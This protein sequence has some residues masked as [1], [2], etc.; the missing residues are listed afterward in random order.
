MPAEVIKNWFR[1]SKYA[2]M[3]G[4]RL[5]PI[6]HPMMK[7][8]PLSVAKGQAEA[9]CMAS[10]NNQR[11]ILKKFHEGKSLDRRYLS[12]VNSVL[13]KNEA[14]IV[15]SSRK[16]LSFMDLRKSAGC[17]YA[18]DLADWLNATILMPAAAGG[19]WA[20][21]ADDIR[22][23]EVQLKRAQRI[24]LARNL[25]GVVSAL[26]AHGCSHRDL[27]SGNVF[28]V[29]TTRQIYLI[30]FDSLYHPSLSMPGATTCGTDGYAA[31][32]AWDGDKLIPGRTW[33]RCADRYALAIL[34]VEFLMLA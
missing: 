4:T 31:P 34:I 25:A 1:S 3:N 30:D 32:Y 5:R 33:C 9:Y 29:I 11:W 8:T 19:D 20:A 7:G 26:E 27:S 28:I 6:E 2:Q 13:P 18:R 24:E 15:G 10:D 16:I 17:Y 21:L 23:G 22:S 14:F 12:S